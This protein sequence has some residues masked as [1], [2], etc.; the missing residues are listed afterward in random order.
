MC[1]IKS[2][3]SY[4]GLIPGLTPNGS[5]WR[6]YNKL[7]KRNDHFLK[8][9]SQVL[10]GASPRP[11]GRFEVWKIKL[12]LLD[13]DLWLEKRK[14]WI[15]CFIYWWNCKPIIVAKDEY[16]DLTEVEYTILV[17]VLGANNFVNDAESVDSLIDI[18]N[19]DQP[20][21]SWKM[22]KLKW[23]LLALLYS[24]FLRLWRS[25]TLTA[26]SLYMVF[27]FKQVIVEAVSTLK[28]M[29]FHNAIL[30]LNARSETNNL[31]HT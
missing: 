31:H 14:S 29:P 2:R 13:R 1:W 12:L 6:P 24:N 20:R 3:E 18:A 7:I 8:A 11:L 19:T 26:P 16:V 17:V 28:I 9:T 21:L 5:T 23:S 25:W 22:M 10:S 30:A 15:R 27:C 4:S